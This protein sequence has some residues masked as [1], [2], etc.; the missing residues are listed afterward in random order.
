ME[1]KQLYE[2]HYKDCA[3]SSHIYKDWQKKWGEGWKKIYENRFK[4]CAVFSVC[5]VMT[6]RE[7]PE[8]LTP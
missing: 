7:P 4:D 3:V 6:P 2:N 8:F 5:L 1:Q